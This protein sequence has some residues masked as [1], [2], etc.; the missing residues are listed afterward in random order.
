MFASIKPCGDASADTFHISRNGEQPDEYLCTAETTDN[1]GLS[2]LAV[3][4]FTH[5]N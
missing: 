1:S 2:N 5:G 3:L 4:E